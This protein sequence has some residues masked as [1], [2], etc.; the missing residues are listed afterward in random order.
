M[1]CCLQE[2]PCPL[3]PED[4]WLASPPNTKQNTF[5]EHAASSAAFTSLT[6]AATPTLPWLS[7]A[8]APTVTA[9]GISPELLLNRCH[10]LG[11]LALRHPSCIPS[12]PTWGGG[13]GVRTP[14]PGLGAAGES[15]QAPTGMLDSCKKTAIWEGRAGCWCKG[16]TLVSP[17]CY[18]CIISGCMSY[19]TVNQALIFVLCVQPSSCRQ[20][21]PQRT[22]QP[23]LDLPQHSAGHWWGLHWLRFAG[24]WTLK[25]WEMFGKKQ[26]VLPQLLL[27]GTTITEATRQNNHLH[28]LSY[29]C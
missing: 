27:Q 22:C 17:R 7:R 9:L 4:T 14:G 26:S 6:F 15:G 24:G 21:N 29:F 25:C 12:L 18:L 5:A 1:F 3:R 10:P 19:L 13:R 2:L 8:R 20:K 28:T 23:F 11:C 16:S